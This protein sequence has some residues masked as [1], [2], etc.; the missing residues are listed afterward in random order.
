M[1]TLVALLMAGAS[2]S[3]VASDWSEWLA[4]AE[5]AQAALNFDG[6]LVVDTG[7]ELRAYDIRQRVTQ[8]GI[9]QSVTALNGADR[10]LVR[11][12]QGVS[13]L[14]G[15][16]DQRLAVAPLGFSSSLMEPLSQAYTVSIGPRDRMAGRDAQRLDFTPRQG[17]R[18]ALRLWL[19]AETALPL[20]GDQLSANG[21]RL[22]R[23]LLAK[24]NVLGF[25]RG[26][27]IPP[28]PAMTPLQNGFVAIASGLPVQGMVN[29]RQWLLTDGV[30]YV[31][32]FTM[33]NPSGISA[34]RNG[35]L[36]QQFVAPPAGTLV[37]LGNAPDGT[38]RALAEAVA[39]RNGE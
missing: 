29:V 14:M 31:S 17:D 19:D 34:W 16:G 26:G 2:A 37:V 23:R 33:P 35:A 8:S 13:V 9:E 4:R 20:R 7:E 24:I 10:R 5:R 12:P 39:Q 25:G 30:A 1:R 6:V 28:S 21:E 15:Q 36:A 18:F 32:V 3:A 38:L 11:G 27:S 22:E